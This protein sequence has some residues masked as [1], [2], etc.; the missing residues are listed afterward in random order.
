MNI[1]AKQKQA[2]AESQRVSELNSKNSEHDVDDI[3]S[4]I[5]TEN[6]QDDDEDLNIF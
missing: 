3:F 5:C 2:E 6:K 4:E 1:V